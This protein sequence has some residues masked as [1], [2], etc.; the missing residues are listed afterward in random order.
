MLAKID[1]KYKKYLMFNLSVFYSYNAQ[2]LSFFDFNSS[3]CSNFEI[4][5][6][7]QNYTISR[8]AEWRCNSPSGGYCS[9]W[10]IVFKPYSSKI[11]FICTLAR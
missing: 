6:T 1:L 9:R 10:C 7:E 11:Y 5:H 8:D 3:D 4:T 2:S